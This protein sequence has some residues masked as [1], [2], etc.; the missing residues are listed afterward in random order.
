MSNTITLMVDEYP[1]SALEPL[2][3]HPLGGFVY[4]GVPITFGIDP[5]GTYLAFAMQPMVTP[6]IYTFGMDDLLGALMALA[7]QA[8]PADAAA[9]APEDAPS[10]ETMLR[11]P[12]S[13]PGSLIIL[14]A[15]DGDR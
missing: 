5:N 13:P 1:A 9:D 3:V 10:A 8:Q 15:R 7:L 6:R 14:G 4:R 2:A 12:Y 11:E